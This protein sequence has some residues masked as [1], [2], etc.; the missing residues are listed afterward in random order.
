M[1]PLHKT[2]PFQ[3]DDVEKMTFGEFPKANGSAWKV[4]L[5]DTKPDDSFNSASQ[6]LS[7]LF[8]IMCCRDWVLQ[9]GKRRALH[10]HRGQREQRLLS[11]LQDGPGVGYTPGYLWKIFASVSSLPLSCAFVFSRR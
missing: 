1:F 5:H 8:C 9:T 6:V 3:R 2:K 4:L 10:S 11:S 7:N